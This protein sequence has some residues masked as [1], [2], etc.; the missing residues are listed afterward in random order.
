MSEKAFI[1]R[2]SNR[3]G[4]NG[5]LIKGI[6]DDAAVVDRGSSYEL[7]ST[8]MFVEGDHFRLDWFTPT[9]IANKCIEASVSDIYAMGGD[10]KFVFVSIA[11]SS[12]VNNDFLN[13]LFDAI[14]ASCEKH[15]AILAG[16]DTTHGEL[17]VIDICV[18]GEVNKNKVLFRNGAREGDLIGVTGQLGGSWAGLE[19]FRKYGSGAFDLVQFKP[20]IMKYLEPN[21]RPDAAKKL[22]GIATSLIDVSDGIGSEIRHICGQSEFGAIVYA[23]KIPIFDNAKVVASYLNHDPL[24]YAISGG[25]DFQL[26]FTAD[27]DS[28]SKLIDLD[29]TIIGEIR[30]ESDILLNIFGNIFELPD[31]YDHFSNNK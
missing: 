6:G 15:G 23:E 13:I 14:I 10:V 27:P 1:M 24:R 7:I 16:G 26:L 19:L 3:V 20:S 28:L 22:A 29:F 11:V 5:N 2:L 17:V 30:K 4:E 25:E 8:D 12:D 31:G 9:Q 21:S 18:V